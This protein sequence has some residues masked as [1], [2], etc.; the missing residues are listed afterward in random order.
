MRFT[1]PQPVLDGFGTELPPDSWLSHDTPGASVMMQV[2]SVGAFVRALLPIRMTGGHT[3]TYG[4]W[5]A[6]DPGE[7]HRIFGVWW[8]PEYVDLRFT[9]WLA[10][11][12]PPWGMLTTLVDAVV[13]DPEHTPYCDRSPDPV[14]SRVLTEEW[15]HT[16][17]LGAL[18]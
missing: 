10:N 7:L 17:V 12:V 14:L 5:L 1:L 8:E 16:D 18:G 11:P 2:P 4:L 9:G 15:Q 13:R 3:L 6:V